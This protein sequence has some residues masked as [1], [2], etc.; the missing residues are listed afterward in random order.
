LALAAG[1]AFDTSGAGAGNGGLEGDGINGRVGETGDA[2]VD[3]TGLDGEGDAA[4]VPVA[5]DR[6]LDVERSS[7]WEPRL[8]WDAAYDWENGGNS[9]ND[10]N[11]QNGGQYGHDDGLNPGHGWDPRADGE[12]SLGDYGDFGDWLIDFINGFQIPCSP[13]S[14]PTGCWLGSVCNPDTSTCEV[15]K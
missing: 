4:D 6:G 13:E 7:D 1:C 5:L 10:H 14:E 8:D 2:G 12:H 9:Q 3:Q 11:S 15:R